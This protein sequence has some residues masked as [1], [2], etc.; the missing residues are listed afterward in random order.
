MLIG[1]ETYWQLLRYATVGLL[2]NLA[3]YGLY[4]A[5]TYLGL[6]PKFTMTLLY[7]TGVLQTY[8][9]NKSWTFKEPCRPGFPFLRYASAYLFGYCIN[10]MA[11]FFCV[12]RLGWPHQVVQGVM[13]IILALL[14]FLLQ[15][16]WVFNQPG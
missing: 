3:L 5:F 11:L 4:L 15:K 1:V 14:L 7:F 6:G 9:F 13:I 2:S 10:W 12:D 16:F 8:F